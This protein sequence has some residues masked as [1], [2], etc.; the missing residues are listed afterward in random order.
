MVVLKQQKCGE[1]KSVGCRPLR[2]GALRPILAGSDTGPASLTGSLG[3]HPRLRHPGL[4]RRHAR[5]HRLAWEG[6]GDG[7]R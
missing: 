3:L 4:H 1:V 2:A 7:G 5:L 6:R